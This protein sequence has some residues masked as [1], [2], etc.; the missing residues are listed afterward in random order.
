MHEA[1]NGDVTE[2]VGGLDSVLMDKDGA[3][4][5]YVNPNPKQALSEAQQARY[6]NQVFKPGEKLHI[7]H[8]A[9]AL[10]EAVDFDQAGE[11]IVDLIRMDMNTGRKWSDSLRQVNTTLTADPTSSTTAWVKIYSYTFPNNQ[12]AVIAGRV[13]CIAGETA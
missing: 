13:A 9:D 6:T 10:A 7:E 11:T 1:V 8:K 3:G 4:T 2:L 12:M 5:L